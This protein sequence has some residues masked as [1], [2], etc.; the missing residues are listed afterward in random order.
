MK[1]N[2]IDMDNW[3][4]KE[5]FNHFFNYAKSTY[6][7]TVNVDITELCNYIREN[8]LRFYPTFTWIV[9]KAIN[10][11]QEF[12]MAFDKEGRL[13]FFDEIGPSYS[14][15]NDKTKVMSDLYTTFSNNFLRF[16]VNMTN[17]LDKYKKNTDFITELQEN[18]FIVSCLPWL[19]YTSFNVNNEGSSPFL[20]PMVTWG[21]F[22]D[23]DNRVLIPL[24]IQV[25]HAVADGYH[26]S[27]FFSDVNRMV[28]NPKQYLRTS[29]KEAGY[30]RYLDEEGRIKVWPSKRSVKYEILKYL[31]TKFE[32]EIYYKEKE[33]NEIIKKWSCLEDFVLLRRELFDN[34]LLSR[35]DDGSRYWVSEVLD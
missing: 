31:I 28:S 5:C 3:D 35:E 22:F 20:F 21:K 2:I 27:L 34:K 15:L 25:H 19:N 33:V 9:S 13:G 18:F 17:H 12:K 7:I 8:K 32:S 1:F 23:K 4:R 26:C 16:Y 30:T 10:N 6:S 24:T 29:K 14:V 11:Y